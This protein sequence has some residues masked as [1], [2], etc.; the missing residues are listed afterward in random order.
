MANYPTFRKKKFYD[1]KETLKDLDPDNLFDSIN[2]EE[3][4]EVD[5]GPGRDVE[6]DDHESHFRG[7]RYSKGLYNWGEFNPESE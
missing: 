6:L 5:N 1:K 2:D 4:E 7:V 3:S